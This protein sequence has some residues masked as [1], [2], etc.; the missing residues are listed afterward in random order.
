M[1]DLPQVGFATLAVH[2]GERAP[3]PDFIPSSTPIYRATSFFYDQAADLDAVFAGAKDG[4]VYSRYGTPTGTALE[5]AVA[6]LE[7]GGYAVGFAS[8]MAAVHGL[9]LAAGVRAGDA[10]VAAQDVYG[11]TYVLFQ[12][13]FAQLGVRVHFVDIADHAQVEAAITHAHPKLMFIETISNPLLKVADIPTLVHIAHTQ[14]AQVAIDNTFATPYL[15]QP[16]AYGV[17]YVVHSATK[18][19]GGHGD[20]T[21]GV[22]VVRRRDQADA[23]RQV[24]KLVGGYLPAAE[25]WLIL[26]GIKTLPL[27][28][29]RQCQ[30]AARIAHW[31]TTLPG[32]GRVIYPGLPSHPQHT[33]A[34]R[35]LAHGLFGAIITFEIDRADR[36]RIF[37]FL[38]ALRLCL[39]ATTLGDVYT[40]F[41]HPASTSHRSLTPEERATIGI[42]EGLVRM[43]VGI[44]DSEDII[45]DVQQALERS[46]KE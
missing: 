10:I 16:L 23:L 11:A 3:F 29:Q 45:A 38:D 46:S 5:T 14:G 12:S 17:D 9:V 1:T 8:G 22:V 20:V 42:S 39:P 44:E 19:L 34:A 24:V 31:L 37:R 13:I 6:L 4:Y 18:Y 40:L 7:G 33:L 36:A 2:G 27:R 15:V 26:R 25:A 41:L 32:I 43:S 35:L 30:N 21:G 28:V